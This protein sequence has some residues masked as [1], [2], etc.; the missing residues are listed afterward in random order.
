MQQLDAQTHSGAQRAANGNTRIFKAKPTDGKR[1]ADPQRLIIAQRHSG[2]R[3]SDTRRLDDAVAP[4]VPRALAGDVAARDA[5]LGACHA[6]V[7]RWAL[8]HT[9]DRDDADDVAQE[10]LIRLCT[11]LHR[12]SGRS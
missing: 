8:V 4:L 2:D 11:R 10:V 1:R 6:T 12:Y 3:L 5:L 9:G 7:Y